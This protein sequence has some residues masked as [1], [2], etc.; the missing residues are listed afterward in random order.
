MRKPKSNAPATKPESLFD[1]IVLILEQTQS[2]V[3]LVVNTKS[4]ER[5]GGYV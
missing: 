4:M 5:T 1:R 3:V 2:N